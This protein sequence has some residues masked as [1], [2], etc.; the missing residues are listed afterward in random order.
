MA[1]PEPIAILGIGCRFPG[2]AGSPEAYW[3][4]LDDG[5]DAVVRVPPGRTSLDP[6]HLVSPWGGFLDQVDGFDPHFF[7]IAPREAGRMDPQQRLFLEVAWEALERA[8]IP[9]EHLAGSATGV[10]AG[11]YNDDYTW[12]Q[13]AHPEELD[14]HAYTGSYQSVLAGRLSY[15]LDLRGPSLAVDTACSSSLVAVHLA[16]RDLWSGDVDLAVAGGV[17]LIVSPL[18][19]RL[20][21]SVLALSATHRCHAFDAAADGFVRG[22]GCGVIILKRLSQAQADGDPVLAVIRGSAVNQDGRSAGLTAPNPDAQEDL[23]RR[24]LTDAGVGP[25]E[26]AYVE[27]HGTGTPVGDPVEAEALSRVL[28]RS[29]GRPC[30]LGSV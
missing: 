23:V 2:G 15:L 11:V 19:N 3:R 25:A 17:N 29:G 28:G 12:L 30:A 27:C 22:E 21:F 26:P 5:V 7:G 13:V 18:S 4:L 8:G 6:E 10:Y 9:A 1:R 24:A 16:C 20:T 14:A